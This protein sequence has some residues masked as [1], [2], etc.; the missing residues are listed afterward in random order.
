MHFFFQ[1]SQ[2]TSNKSLMRANAHDYVESS[3][4]MIHFE[5]AADKIQLAKCNQE[6]VQLHHLKD[7]EFFFHVKVLELKLFLSRLFKLNH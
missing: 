2:W 6:D 1:N 4:M 5:E 3:R 7:S